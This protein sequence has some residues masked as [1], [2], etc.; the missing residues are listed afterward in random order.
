MKQVILFIFLVSSFLMACDSDQTNVGGTCY[1]TADLDALVA[2]ATNS[3]LSTDLVDVIAMGASQIWDNGRL[4]S[5]MCTNCNL[6][7]AIPS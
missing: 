5:W 6:A 7:G 2:F 4:T 3:G 1:K